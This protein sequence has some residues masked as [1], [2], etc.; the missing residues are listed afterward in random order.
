MLASG[1]IA[2]VLAL[3]DARGGSLGHV[4]FVATTGFVL[5]APGWAVIGFLPRLGAAQRWILALAS[6]TAIAIVGGQ[7]ML[8]T[9]WWHPVAALLVL[10]LVCL[11]VLTRH[12]IVYW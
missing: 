6:S 5:L 8:L 9:G 7:L 3:I 11:P 10:V 2:A 1:V 12:A 4:R